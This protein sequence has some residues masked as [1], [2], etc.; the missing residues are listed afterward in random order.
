MKSRTFKSLLLGLAPF[1]LAACGGGEAGPGTPSGG[2]S[3]ACVALGCGADQKVCV[4]DAA[5]A[6]CEGCPSGAYAASSGT[7]EKLSGTPR[8]HTFAE[9]TV[10]AGQEIKGLCQS[11]TLN[12]ATEIWVNAVELQQ[13]ESSHHSNWTFVPADKFDG[14]DGIWKCSERD[15]DQVSAALAGGVIY[16]QSTQTEREVQKFPDGVAVRIPPYSRIIGDVHL[17]NTSLAPVT[18]TLT[19]TLYGI[20]KEEVKH[21]LTPFHL[22]YHGLAIPPHAKSRFYGEC[23][24]E[25]PF[26]ASGN[27]FDQ[28]VYYILPHTHTMA[29]RFFLE[30]MGGPR[31]GETILELS[32]Y[33]GEAHGRVY[34]KPIDM[35]GAEGYR[36]GCEYDNPRDETVVWGFG[37]EEMCELLGFAESSVG[38]EAVISSAQEVG[39]DGDLRLFSAPCVTY[40]FPWDHDKPGGPPPP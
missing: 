7:C 20:P 13:N 34:E 16:A 39:T 10:E 35:T 26:A 1:V 37:D 12:N 9:F 19:L 33:N 30:I 2:P 5:G 11:V 8:A 38:F 6:R 40:A 14:P 36:F 24:M 25:G 27:T 3:A 4:E 29:K 28:K 21:K 22:D 15:Y 17:L 32:A 23:A 31:D 18:G